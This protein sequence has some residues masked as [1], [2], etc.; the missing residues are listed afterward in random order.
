MSNM[1]QTTMLCIIAVVLI[2]IAA[3]GASYK[4]S[5]EKF[6]DTNPLIV[7]K[8]KTILYNMNGMYNFFS[9][10]DQGSPIYN[11][12]VTNIDYDN[13]VS[14]LLSFQP[15]FVDN[16]CKTV[17]NANIDTNRCNNLFID[18]VAYPDKYF[19]SISSTEPLCLT[20]LS[21]IGSKSENSYVRIFNNIYSL[22]KRCVKFDSI[23]VTTENHDAGTYRM[24]IQGNIKA[25]ALS[26]PL[27][28]AFGTYGL[29]HVSYNSGLFKSYDSTDFN[30]TFFILQKV[31]DY[32]NA[33]L[34]PNTHQTLSMAS[35]LTTLPITAYYLN[36]KQP[37]A[38]NMIPN[39]N[40]P[41]SK[42][43]NSLS[44]IL[45]SSF[46]N[47]TATT[48]R[49]ISFVLPT[50]FSNSSTSTLPNSATVTISYNST[51]TSADGIAT[52][53]VKSGKDMNDI[54]I[55]LPPIFL[56]MIAIS[57]KDNI[58]HRFHICFTY[59][60]DVFTTICFFEEISTN[61][62]HVFMQRQTIKSG[63]NY[64]H[65]AYDEDNLMNA[66]PAALKHEIEKYKEFCTISSIPNY[67]YVA[68][69]LGYNI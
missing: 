52:I 66:I 41:T 10:G 16:Y 22:V 46:L 42:I 49:T 7:N 31:K 18:T 15:N 3:I 24:T 45:S 60:M 50:S 55:L 34:Y 30:D 68:K 53:V 1:S 44:M 38:S 61:E 4:G 37:I 67:A 9:S 36:Y 20:V 32:N 39:G 26:R 19:P 62:Q 48:S 43:N 8:T 11:A 65:V 33:S 54:A 47:K 69:Y 35:D 14:Y 2:V 56:N 57:R 40:M 6:T 51:A 29:Y 63:G 17:T 21:S 59:S 58:D 28:M 13:F 25:F 5:L 12:S 27:F 64:V 23:S